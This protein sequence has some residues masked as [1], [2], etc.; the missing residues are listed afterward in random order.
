M[1]TYR[2]AAAGLSIPAMLGVF[3]AAMRAQR[4]VRSLFPKSKRRGLRGAG[5]ARRPARLARR[6]AGGRRLLKGR[7]NKM[8]SRAG[9][10]TTSSMVSSFRAT[11]QVSAMCKVAAPNANVYQSAVTL[12]SPFGFQGATAWAWFSRD[13]LSTIGTQFSTG[14]SSPRRYVLDSMIG[15]LTLTNNSTATSEVM[16]YDIVCKRDIPYT[17]SWIMGAGTY[18]GYNSNPVGYWNAGVDAGSGAPSGSNRADYIGSTPFDS[19]FFRDY[20]KVVKRTDVILQQGGSHRHAVVLS[21]RKLIDESVYGQITQY[22]LKGYTMFTMVVHKGTPVSDVSGATA[23][24]GESQ[25]GVVQNWRIK[26]FWVADTTNTLF[27]QDTLTTPATASII[28][29]GS[30]QPEAVRIV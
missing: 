6:K 7:S 29:V 8:V 20:F 12:N 23:T 15:D 13:T 25:L 3:N 27:Y 4:N 14:T 1:S 2:S 30:G 5:K 19:Q 10:L 9:L 21:P 11:P 26:Y 28:N 16:I 17:Q 18:S 22:G 24:I